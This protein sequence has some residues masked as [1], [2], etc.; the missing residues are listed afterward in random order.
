MAA[1]AY[2]DLPDL[3]LRARLLLGLL[4]LMP[5]GVR[6]G[7]LVRTYR[8]GGFERS[9]GQLGFD[10][11]QALLGRVGVEV[12]WDARLVGVCA[13]MPRVGAAR[14]GGRVLDRSHG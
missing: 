12:P 8:H 6:D 7:A 10:D 9:P 5:D 14:D 1:P 2:P 13:V 3:E 11:V 4:A